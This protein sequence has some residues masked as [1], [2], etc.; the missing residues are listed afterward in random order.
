MPTNDVIVTFCYEKVFLEFDIS[1]KMT[2]FCMKILR[3][4]HLSSRKK[5]RLRNHPNLFFIGA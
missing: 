4:D 1:T 2:I 3:P 5:K